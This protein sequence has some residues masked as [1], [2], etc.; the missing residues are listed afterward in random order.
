MLAAWG[1]FLYAPFSADPPTWARAAIFN[2]G[3][4]R[5][6]RIGN[7]Q[8]RIEMDYEDGED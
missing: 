4:A 8:R 2:L 3:M 6:F 1:C 7:I 5:W